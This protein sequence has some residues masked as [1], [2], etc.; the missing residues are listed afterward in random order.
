MN[1][2][3]HKL[4]ASV[5]NKDGQPSCTKIS[6]ARSNGRG[7][8]YEEIWMEGVPPFLCAQL[9]RDVNQ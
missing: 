8:I 4:K 5:F 3:I 2:A 9:Q 6:K 1:Q 7:Y